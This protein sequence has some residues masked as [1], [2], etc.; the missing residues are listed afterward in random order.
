ME[1]RVVEQLE[2]AGGLYLRV[3]VC[4]LTGAVQKYVFKYCVF[5]H[6]DAFVCRSQRCTSAKERNMQCRQTGCD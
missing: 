2:Q 4:I 6:V 3:H 5:V 1:L